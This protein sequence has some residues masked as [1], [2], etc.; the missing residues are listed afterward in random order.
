MTLCL[1][2]LQ[3]VL[4]QHPCPICHIKG[5]IMQ[6]ASDVGSGDGEHEI[7]AGLLTLC[8]P[9]AE[10]PWGWPTPKSHIGQSAQLPSLPP[11]RMADSAERSVCVP[12]QTVSP[13]L[14][15]EESITNSANVTV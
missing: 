10:Q 14:G 6:C 9:T 7:T 2:L 5:C 12:R 1:Y 3:E 8:I 11:H 15:D 13:A 4:V